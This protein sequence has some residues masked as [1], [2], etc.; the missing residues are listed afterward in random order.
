VLTVLIPCLNEEGNV[1]KIFEGV[2]HLRDVPEVIIIEGN[3]TDQT[4]EKLISSL[5]KFKDSRIRVIRQTGRG[6]FNAILE[7]ARQSTSEH[8][9]IWDGDMTIDYH[10]QNN[11]I[12]LY[13][14]ASPDDKNRFVTANRLNPQISDSAMRP[15]NKLGNHLFA[16][17]IKW[18]VSIDVPDALA[19]SKIFPK[20]LLE[21]K[22]ICKIALGLDPFGDLFLLAQIKKHDL[23][24]ISLN[25]EYKARSYGT[26]NINRWSGGVEMLKFLAHI[27]THN[28]NSLI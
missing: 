21:D 11:L 23:K 22:E 17:L 26:T 4:Y 8:L 5:E 12:E 10:D 1:D 3:S 16:Y 19:G 14:H 20:L 7:G 27:K 15:L 2:Q 6:K 13:L 28:C 9:A 24:F 18:I 25:C